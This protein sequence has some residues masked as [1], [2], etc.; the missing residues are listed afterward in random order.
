MPKEWEICIIFL[1]LRFIM[2]KPKVYMYWDY[3]AFKEFMIMVLESFGMM[4]QLTMTD[5]I[6]SR[7]M[8]IHCF[9]VW[10]H[11]KNLMKSAK[12]SG[13]LDHLWMSLCHYFGI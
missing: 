11:E 1:D 8:D 3:Y 4:A 9:H 2:W 10:H 5:L 12:T 6:E 13:S 7:L